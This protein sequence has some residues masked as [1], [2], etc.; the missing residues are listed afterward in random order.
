MRLPE[1]IGDFGKLGIVQ[2]KDWTCGLVDLWTC[3]LVDRGLVDSWTLFFYI[4]LKCKKEALD[5]ILLLICTMP[6]LTRKKDLVY[7]LS[8]VLYN[9]YSLR[10]NQGQGVSVDVGLF[11]SYRVSGNIDLIVSKIKPRLQVNRV[12][13]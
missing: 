6:H 9:I 3:G 2:N 12:N 11:F 4:L 5:M 1:F 10:I 8:F 7:F 13:N